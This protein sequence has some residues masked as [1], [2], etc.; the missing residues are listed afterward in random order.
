MIRKTG[1]TSKYRDISN[2]SYYLKH[3]SS[4]II[5]W[6]LNL[7]LTYKRALFQC[8]C[9]EWKLDS[10]SLCSSWDKASLNNCNA[11]Y[12]LRKLGLTIVYAT[13]TIGFFHLLSSSEDFSIQI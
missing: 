8:L 2:M 12:V 13:L 7:M 5:T 11:L 6:P 10:S 3:V 4:S 9:G 1:V